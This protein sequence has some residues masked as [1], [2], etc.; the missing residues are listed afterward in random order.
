[1]QGKSTKPELLNEKDYAALPSP[2]DKRPVSFDVFSYGCKTLFVVC[3]WPLVA[4]PVIMGAYMYLHTDF[5]SGT[6]S[7]KQTNKQADHFQRK[8]SFW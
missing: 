3:E 7:G 6:G 2:Q 1:M 4:R 8:G 5:P